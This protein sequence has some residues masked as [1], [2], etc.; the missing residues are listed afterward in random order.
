M[1]KTTKK[2]AIQVVRPVAVPGGSHGAAK[3]S[4]R[5]MGH[6]HPTAVI[7]PGAKIGSDVQVGPFCYIGPNVTI[8]RGCRLVS[9]VTLLGHTT[10]GAE[11][12]LW[13]QVTLGA[14]PQ[15]LK[16][17]GEQTR[18]EIGDNNEIRESVTMHPG[19]ENGGG[20]TRVGSDNMIMVGAHVAHDCI[21]GDH[22]VLANAVHLAGHIH[23]QDHAVVSGATAVHHYVT[24]G[25]YAFIGG[26]T[27]I[28][29]DA[30]PFMIH[31]GNPSR[32]R[33]VN[34]IGLSR[35][36]FPQ[37]T[38]QRLKDVYRRLY[39]NS[40]S[41]ECSGGGATSMSEHLSQI[42]SDYPQDTCVSLLVQFV[43]NSSIGLH[44]RHLESSRTDSRRSNPV[45]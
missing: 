42:E 13:P 23:I 40:S 10:L 4:Q 6:I 5:K 7:E 36:Q 26:M 43:R 39:K 18:L 35:H 32:V 37:E 1:N 29:H 27:R 11:N 15:D 16:Y 33:G 9:H 24:I 3:E 22:V 2:P 31:E 41:G 21:I 45:R 14:D 19:T 38:V 8:G 25:Q 34:A 28:V 44:G 12:I 20:L 17:Q 30:V